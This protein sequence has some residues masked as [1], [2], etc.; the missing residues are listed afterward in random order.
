[1]DFSCD[2][3]NDT[4]FIGYVTYLSD[5]SLGGG[6][7]KIRF[8]GITEDGAEQLVVSAESVGTEAGNTVISYTDVKRAVVLQ[9][10]SGWVKYRIDLKSGV[11]AILVVAVNGPSL[12]NTTE[13]KSVFS[14]AWLRLEAWLSEALLGVEPRTPRAAQRISA[15]TPAPS[16]SDFINIQEQVSERSMAASKASLTESVRTASGPESFWKNVKATGSTS[17][18]WMCSC[19]YSNPESANECSNCFKRKK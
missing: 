5:G 3:L 8:S 13:H 14:G 9:A 7:G 6:Y 4:D 1:M 17:G 2:I 16:N 12:T 19:G 15:R 11:V 18:K 10:T